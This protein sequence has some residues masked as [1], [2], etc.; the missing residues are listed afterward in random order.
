MPDEVTHTP[1]PWAY[2]EG[3][4]ERRASSQVFKANDKDF[5]VAFV[6]CEWL[7]PDQRA[8][9][10]ANARLIASAPELLAELVETV[11]W[12]EE[13]ASILLAT[14]NGMSREIERGKAIEVEVVRLRGR[15]A[16]L[17]LIIAK[18]KGGA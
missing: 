17:R 16:L 9:D 5:V 1:G 14:I 4:A 7:N 10:I 15:A 11:A 2:A 8:E 6:T 18:A 12:L 13:R 3:D